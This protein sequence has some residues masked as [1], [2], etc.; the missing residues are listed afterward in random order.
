MSAGIVSRED[1]PPSLDA[2][3]RPVEP[4]RETRFRR[5]TA[6]LSEVEA[7]RDA[8]LAETVRETGIPIADLA[9]EFDAACESVRELPALYDEYAAWWQRRGEAF[10]HEYEVVPKGRV[11]IVTPWNTPLLSQLF[12]PALSYYAGNATI[13]K[14]SSEASAATAA[15][16]DA[17]SRDDHDG[18]PID[19]V[20]A[21]GRAVADALDVSWVDYVYFMGAR[22]IGTQVRASFDG[23]FFGEY[24]A[25]N[26]AVV[27]EY[28]EAHVDAVV[29]AATEKS[30]VDCDNLRGVFAPADELD[31]IYDALRAELD[32]LVVGDPLD[33]ETDLGEDIVPE[34]VELVRS[35]SRER[36]H[37]VELSASLWL[38]PY[39]SRDDLYEALD[40]FFESSPWGLS[41]MVLSSSPDELV[42]RL[43][44][45]DTTRI[46]VNKPSLEFV[47]HA[48]WGGRGLTAD[49]GS[50]P[51]IEK[52]TDTI[53]VERTH[54]A[55]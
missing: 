7:N 11:L 33:H 49:G 19:A 35:P 51:W 27:T 50:R 41:T 44:R 6:A 43:K 28:D 15:L 36:R 29:R 21:S 14:P 53:A 38:Q 22:E 23:E 13:V 8:I 1:V 46:C 25:N 5:I 31:R 20:S 48:P 45:Y 18:V 47:P 40:R 55:P 39:E 4:S 17:F 12:L 52:F 2:A 54:G 30:G 32:D 3:W 9:E 37:A 26:V 42:S 10:G 16:T 34:G 24:E